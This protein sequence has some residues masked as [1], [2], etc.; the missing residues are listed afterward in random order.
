MIILKLE[1]LNL[2][3][4]KVYLAL[5]TSIFYFDTVMVC[6]NICIAQFKSALS[7]SMH[8]A[9]PRLRE[10]LPSMLH[11]VSFMILADHIIHTHSPFY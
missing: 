11:F 2:N 8:R 5:I 1:S 7:F 10:G 3:G 4:F 6:L 9:S